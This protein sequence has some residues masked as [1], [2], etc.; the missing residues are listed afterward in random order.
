M[1]ETLGQVLFI[2]ELVFVCCFFA[3]GAYRAAVEA[4]RIGRNTQ[5]FDELAVPVWTDLLESDSGTEE[6]N[7]QQYQNVQ[8][9]TDTGTQTDAAPVV[10]APV[11]QEPLWRLQLCNK[12]DAIIASNLQLQATAAA[13]S[14]QASVINRQQR[15]L[16]EANRVNATLTAD[17][18]ESLATA[19]QRAWKVKHL[20]LEAE[21]SGNQASRWRINCNNLV[22]RL[23]KSKLE[24]EH[25][26]ISGKEL[27]TSREQCEQAQNTANEAQRQQAESEKK[28]EARL[29]SLKDRITELE[30]EKSTALGQKDEALQ[31]LETRSKEAKDDEAA[32]QKAIEIVKNN[33]AAELAKARSA[34]NTDNDV[35]L[36]DNKKLA[37][38]IDLLK[39]EQAKLASQ[40]S[41]AEQENAALEAKNKEYERGIAEGKELVASHV[42]TIND[43]KLQKKEL[44]NAKEELDAETEAL[45]GELTDSKAA[46]ER[47]EAELKEL[48]DQ[49]IAS[50]EAKEAMTRELK[51]L[52]E[53]KE[54]REQADRT[55]NANAGAFGDNLFADVPDTTD[56]A[57]TQD[58]E[59]ASSQLQTQPDG[60]VGTEVRD[61]YDP[62]NPDAGFTTSAADIENTEAAV[63]QIQAQQDGDPEVD[64]W[65]EELA[66]GTWAHTTDH[67]G[68]M[69]TDPTA[70]T[71]QDQPNEAST[72][73]AYD[74]SNPTARQNEGSAGA[75]AFDLST[76][77]RNKLKGTN[78]G[79][80]D[81]G[82]RF[83]NAN[84]GAPQDSH[85]YQGNQADHQSIEAA[86]DAHPLQQANDDNDAMDT[87]E[88]PA[89]L[90]EQPTWSHTNA[91]GGI[92]GLVGN[93]NPGP[94]TG[95]S[96]HEL[97]G[98]L[99]P[100]RGSEHGPPSREITMDD[101]HNV[102]DVV[103]QLSSQ[104]PTTSTPAGPSNAPFA[105][106]P[107]EQAPVD[108]PMNDAVVAPRTNPIQ[109]RHI[110]TPHLPRQSQSVG[111][112][113]LP[114]QINQGTQIPGLVT[115]PAV[116]AQANQ[117]VH[118]PSPEFDPATAARIYGGAQRPQ[119]PLPLVSP[120]TAAQADQRVH[121]PSQEFGAAAAARIYGGAPRPQHS[122][123]LVSPATAAQA[124]RGPLGTKPF[125]D[126]NLPIRPTQVPQDQ[127]SGHVST[128]GLINKSLKPTNEGA[129]G[130][131]Q[132][133]TPVEKPVMKKRKPRD[134]PM[135][136]KSTTACGRKDQTPAKS[137][138][139]DEGQTT[140]ETA[141]AQQPAP[142]ESTPAEQPTPL[143]N[144]SLPNSPSPLKS[145]PPPNSPPP[146]KIL[147]GLHS[148]A[149]GKQRAPADEPP[150]PQ[151]PLPEFEHTSAQ[152]AVRAMVPVD[153][154]LL[155]DG[156][157]EDGKP[158]TETKDDNIG[159]SARRAT[160]A[161][162]D[163]DQ[164][165]E[166]APKDGEGEAK[167]PSAQEKV[168][169]KA[170]ASDS[171]EE[172]DITDW[173]ID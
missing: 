67:T 171:G 77:D 127:Q 33:A 157:D 86:Q 68:Y 83:S 109:G 48:Q 155:G 73:D 88:G 147:A 152:A 61:S 131:E 166:I 119:H 96:I 154:A 158:N 153:W 58:T 26:I 4:F 56:I 19:S 80:I 149:A 66:A 3:V 105:T 24:K 49:Q 64:A 145:L 38:E 167:A 102:A 110:R 53:F 50:N 169:E 125:Q 7:T 17:V 123:P 55:L 85:H 71:S 20:E 117:R 146:L 161:V 173:S 164:N 160:G 22:H 5:S 134:N 45:R 100:P 63:P 13:T 9:M 133:E 11:D 37:D 143:K 42:K 101:R 118:R 107:S 8:T 99:I 6:S 132:K 139:G 172:D 108:V 95:G 70:P 137:R 18:N 36:R 35:L 59:F 122:L 106:R 90:D 51:E 40:N 129:Q 142:Q 138:T 151:Q 52:R 98:S 121:R 141:A 97:L 136:I 82:V 29:D 41:T 84:T 162:I 126:F 54:R 44:E 46:K 32:H 124:S 113:D 130:S 60:V 93:V 72:S 15:E 89:G 78:W 163:D 87:S 116:T 81:A 74:P 165:D 79:L 43:L 156:T 21:F 65:A 76:V 91:A 94:G 30:D 170:P 25:R 144:L 47:V 2:A 28:A 150:P 112:P 128:T 12:L 10:N 23:D 168:Q 27:K 69:D 14:A 120:A 1:S 57:D 39:K 103:A 115:A 140:K 111:A 75:G 31:Q 135:V 148:R 16:D 62:F 92:P 159:K 104:P 34:D 114:D